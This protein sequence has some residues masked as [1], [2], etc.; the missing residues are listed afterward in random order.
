M[1]EQSDF[2]QDSLP[3]PGGRPGRS[4]AAS[5]KS[6]RDD[7]IDVEA[8]S[9][10]LM[11]GTAAQESGLHLSIGAAVLLGLL[12]VVLVALAFFFGLVLGRSVT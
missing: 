10:P 5:S 11:M 8:V 3:P 12:V 2:D 4:G 9:V 7:A 1:F 6:M